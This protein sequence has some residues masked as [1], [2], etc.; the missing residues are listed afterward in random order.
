[1]FQVNNENIGTPSNVVLVSLLL[2]LNILIKLIL[3]PTDLTL[4]MPLPIA[5]IKMQ[6]YNS[7]LYVGAKFFL[8]V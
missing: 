3:K 2:T 8:D 7:I 6:I 5:K 4:S 1:M